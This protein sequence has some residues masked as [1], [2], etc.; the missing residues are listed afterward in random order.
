[1]LTASAIKLFSKGEHR[2]ELGSP[3]KASTSVHVSH[4]AFRNLFFFQ[5]LRFYVS[6]ENESQ[7]FPKKTSDL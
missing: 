4:L 3:G 6:G 5:N 2:Q 1:M 7:D